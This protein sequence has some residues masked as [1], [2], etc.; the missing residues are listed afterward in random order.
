[1]IDFNP[2][3]FKNYVVNRRRYIPNETISL[4]KDTIYYVS[5]DLIV[6]GWRAI[7]KRPD[8]SGGISAYLPKQGIKTSKLF[9]ANGKL[10]YWYNDIGEVFFS[11]KEIKFN[12]L[13]LDVIV[14]PDGKVNYMDIDEF[15]LAIEKN[16]ITKEQ[17]LKALRS[18]HYLV[19]AIANEEF[20]TLTSPIEELEAYLNSQSHSPF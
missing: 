18:Y 8:F 16:L 3:R 12:D 13:L 10:L 15:A 7:T 19:S 1:M 14:Y 4:N 17:E 5:D 11:G 20:H 9:D 2:Q 6:T